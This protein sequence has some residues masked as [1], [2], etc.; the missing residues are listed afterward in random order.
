MAITRIPIATSL[1]P[2][3]AN[4]S[5]VVDAQATTN[6]IFTKYPEG[7]LFASQ[8]YP[9]NIFQNTTQ[10]SS[11]AVSKGA[12]RGIYYWNFSIGGVSSDYTV[13][14]NYDKIYYNTYSSAAIQTIDTGTDLVYFY[15]QG[16]YLIILDPQNNKG[17]YVEK[18]AVNTITSLTSVSGWPF[19]GDVKMAGGGAV[20]NGTLYIMDTDGKI[21][22][23]QPNNP[24]TA[25]VG[26][27]FIAASRSTD[28]GVFLCSQHDQIVAIS[29]KTIEFFYDAGNP[30]GSPLERRQDLFYNT[31]CADRRRVFDSGDTIFFLGAERTG[32]IS[33]KILQDF[34]LTDVS[35]DSL[36]V[37]LNTVIS[38]TSAEFLVSGATVA[39]RKL[40]FVTSV[41]K[42]VPG[43][44]GYGSS[45][46]SGF[47]SGF[48]SSSSITYEVWIPYSTIAYDLNGGYWSKYT[49]G[50]L[51]AI[52]PSSD[53]PVIGTSENGIGLRGALGIMTNGDVFQYDLT[54]LYQDTIG[55]IGVYVDTASTYMTSPE[56]YVFDIATASAASINFNV[57][58]PE[59]D[60]DVYPYKYLS[61][62]NLVGDTLKG[63]T[64]LS[65]IG[66]AWSDDGYQ[67]QSVERSLETGKRRSLTRLGNFK[68]RAFYLSYTGTDKLQI[69]G[70][71]VD[72]RT[73]GYA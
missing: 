16:N 30:V 56:D 54:G 9:I 39:G 3:G 21:W 8:R 37:F 41:I 12:G 71:E 20:L 57:F 33:A 24:T 22:N 43:S 11:T 10:P 26:I 27:D 65:P 28:S 63:A 15:E 19:T 7:K 60:Q 4:G 42:A 62:F 2:V 31:G 32:T 55:S 53:Y 46:S 38:N 40:F 73:S 23:S 69:E 18:S 61:R 59:F 64:N 25:W 14:V 29:S 70:I 44:L 66:V 17:W 6:C 5:A 68:R 34:T 1:Y 13:I 47:S 50:S 49:C 45:F 35:E 51:S 52:N 72:T 58:T 67:T 36:D 48:G